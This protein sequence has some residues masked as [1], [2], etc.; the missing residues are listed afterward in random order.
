MK[1]IVDTNVLV[2]AILR[3]N[4]PE[5]V[6][7]WIV[8]QPVIEWIATAEIIQEYREVLQRKKF[9]LP[10]DIIQHWLELLENEIVLVFP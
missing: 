3:D 9:K 8:M 6:I 5:Q 1:V 4:L 2:S 10:N 7:M